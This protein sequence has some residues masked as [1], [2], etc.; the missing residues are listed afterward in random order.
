MFEIIKLMW[1][2]VV[3]RDAARK[4]QLQWRTWAVAIGFVLVL[5]GIGLPAALLYD[6]HPEYKPLF[7]AA[8]V[9]V[10]GA[11]ATLIWLVIRWRLW[12]PKSRQPG[13]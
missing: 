10:A 13:N 11:V 5:Y 7:I 8:M 12:A 4:G 2:V 3:L 1:D 6:A 9:L